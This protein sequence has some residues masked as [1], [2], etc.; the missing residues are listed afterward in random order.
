MQGGC[1]DFIRLASIY[2]LFTDFWDGSIRNLLGS[3]TPDP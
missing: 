1:D 2:Q 3:V